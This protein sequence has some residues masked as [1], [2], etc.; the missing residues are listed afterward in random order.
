[1]NVRR[2]QVV[3][4][5]CGL[6]TGDIE[7]VNRGIH[8]QRRVSGAEG[9]SR[10]AVRVVAARAARQSRVSRRNLLRVRQVNREVGR[11]HVG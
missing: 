1:M 6:R 10:R 4:G 8:C 2:N 11:R 3:I 5:I 7:V 9:E